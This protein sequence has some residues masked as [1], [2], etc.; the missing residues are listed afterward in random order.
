MNKLI[1]MIRDRAFRVAILAKYGLLNWMSDEQFLKLRWRTLRGNVELNL[2]QPKTYNEKLQWLKIH[3]RKPIYT[4][5]V[6]KLAAR[7]F[8]KERIGEEYLIPLLAVLSSQSSG[9]SSPVGEAA[10]PS[11]PSKKGLVQRGRAPP[12]ASPSTH[13]FWALPGGL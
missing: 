7:D 5:M 6:D 8:V 9:F 10:A 13:P 12:Q 11:L 3:D 1:R 2:Q 4:T